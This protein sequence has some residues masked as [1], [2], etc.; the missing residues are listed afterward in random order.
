LSIDL[1]ATL[2]ANLHLD[3][4]TPILPHDVR[5]TPNLL[6]VMGNKGQVLQHNALVESVQPHK[7]LVE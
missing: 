7:L 2:Y 1:S 3:G 6:Q 5:A 4:T